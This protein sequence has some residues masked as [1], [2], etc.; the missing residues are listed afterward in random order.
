MNSNFCFLSF[1]CTCFFY[2]FFIYL[3]IIING[4][5]CASSDTFKLKGEANVSSEG[6]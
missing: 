2:F 1:F 3:F 6:E 5:T 4:V